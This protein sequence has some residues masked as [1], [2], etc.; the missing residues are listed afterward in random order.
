[1]K[2]LRYSLLGIVMFF[3]FFSF[4]PPDDILQS[5]LKK[6]NDYHQTHQQEKIYLHIDKPFYAAGDNVWFKTYL[7]EASLHHLDSRSKVVYVDL[8]NSSRKVLQHKVLPIVE[9]ISLGDFKL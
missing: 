8:L 4:A 9:G 6:V 1:M 3:I 5:I 2:T 7:V